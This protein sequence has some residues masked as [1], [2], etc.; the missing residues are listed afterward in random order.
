MYNIYTIIFIL[1]QQ[2]KSDSQAPEAL[3]R[4]KSVDSGRCADI[5]AASLF[6]PAL[7]MW[8]TGELEDWEEGD[9]P[10]L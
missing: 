3:I 9:C 1:Y 2:S 7:S 10:I 6:T 5:V 4:F 8:L